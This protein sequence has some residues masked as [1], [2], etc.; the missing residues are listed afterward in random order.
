MPTDCL[1][2]ESRPARASE[3]ASQSLSQSV[4]QSKS[5]SKR[6]SVTHKGGGGKKEDAV[7]VAPQA[8]HEQTQTSTTS[9]RGLDGRDEPRARRVGTHNAHAA[10]QP[11]EESEQ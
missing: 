10:R 6:A 9:T 4:S 8:G 11:D 3:P 1:T 7:V 5:Q 2:A